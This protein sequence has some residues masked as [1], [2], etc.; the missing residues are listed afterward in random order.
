MIKSRS[1]HVWA[2][3]YPIPPFNTVL[4]HTTETKYF[5]SLPSLRNTCDPRYKK[6][7][8]KREYPISLQLLLILRVSIAYVYSLWLF[9]ISLIS[10][11][12]LNR[13]IQNQRIQFDVLRLLYDDFSRMVDLLYN[14]LR[15]HWQ[16][17]PIE[18]PLRFVSLLV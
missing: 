15:I 10:T 2:P 7:V 17:Y 8:T 18:Y 3:F 4:F 14:L 11:K 16:I 5:L 9:S 6:A 12:T 13:V 1:R